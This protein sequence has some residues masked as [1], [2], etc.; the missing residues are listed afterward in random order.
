MSL[1]IDAHCHLFNA[2][3][4]PIKGFIDSRA[5]SWIAK[6]LDRWIQKHTPE[7]KSMMTE[8]EEKE[9]TRE[10]IHFMLHQILEEDEKLNQMF[11]AE[12]AKSTKEDAIPVLDQIELIYRYI[13][14]LDLLMKNR[15][16]IMQKMFDTYPEVHLFTP[17][18]MD[19]EYWLDDP[20]VYTMRKRIEFF[21]KMIKL[22]KGLIHPFVPFDPKREFKNKGTDESAM[23]LIKDAID[24]RGFIGVKVYPPMG[25]RPTGNTEIANKLSN[26]EAYDEYFDE[27]FTYCEDNEIPITTHCTNGGAQAYEKSGEH[28]NPEFWEPALQGHPGLIVN[29]AHFGGDD[30]FVNDKEESWTW[31]IG[32]LMQHYDNVYADTG[33]HSIVFDKRLRKKFFQQLQHLLNAFPKVKDRLMYGSDYHMIVR[34]EDNKMF[35]KRYL[36][37]YSDHFNEAETNQFIGGDAIEFLRLRP[38][39]QNRNRLYQFYTRNEI[40]CPVWWNL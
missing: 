2:D 32:E 10:Q 25:Y 31:K 3:D 6:I 29:F 26:A 17:L 24:N 21:E 1:V 7:D 22:S 27:L 28:A 5:P 23:S 14:W 16:V 11:K 33:H 30:E 35:Y 40:E 13:R 12:M 4:I 37:A 18:M 9:L 8:D 15:P 39:D 36:D 19:M 38:G 34:A 20:V